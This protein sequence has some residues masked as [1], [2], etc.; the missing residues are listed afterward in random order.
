MRYCFLQ[1]FHD[2]NF[3]RFKSHWN[4][5]VQQSVV[6]IW[7]LLREKIIFAFRFLSI[8]VFLLRF[9]VIWQWLYNFINTVRIATNSNLSRSPWRPTRKY[10]IDRQQNSPA[11]TEL[12]NTLLGHC[13]KFWSLL[14]KVTFDRRLDDNENDKQK[15]FNITNK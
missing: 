3:L 11:C 13:A 8:I 15:K 6:L 5:K 9:T 4:N 14:V 7:L 2:K 10:N 1:A 12:T